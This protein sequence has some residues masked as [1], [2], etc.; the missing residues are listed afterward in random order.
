MLRRVEPGDVDLLVALNADQD[1]MRFIDRQPPT[2]EQ[3]EAEVAQTDGE[4]RHA[5]VLTF[6]IDFDDPLPGTELGEVEYEITGT[7]WQAARDRPA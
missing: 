2:R 5:H 1:V 4:V 3:V 7:D 6:H